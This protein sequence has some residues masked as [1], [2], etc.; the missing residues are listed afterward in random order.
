MSTSSTPPTPPPG[1]PYVQNALVCEKV[2]READGVQ[3]FIRIVDRVTVGA[4]G[5]DVPTEMPPQ[6]LDLTLALSLKAGDAR[7]RY[8]LKVRPE[9]PS[10]EQMPSL[11][12]HLQVEGGERG[13]NVNIGLN[14]IPFG[15]EG[16]W[17]FDILFG[18]HEVLL[19][20]VPLRL[21]YQ[22]QRVVETGQTE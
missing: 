17:W 13:N 12:V 9:M 1:G 11:E 21:S 20:R 22:P 7:G 3:S 10:G 19:T 16:L 18:D 6:T 15:Q 4:V 5:T 8:A 2:L 14:G